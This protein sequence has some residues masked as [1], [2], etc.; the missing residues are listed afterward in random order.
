MT[1]A[2]LIFVILL[3]AISTPLSIQS[4]KT[5]AS[6]QVSGIVADITGARIVRAQVA[7]EGGGIRYDA[8]TG[9]EGEYNISLKPG[10]YQIEV[11][12]FGFCTARRAPFR[13]EPQATANFDFMLL[14]C[15]I[16]NRIITENGKYKGESCGPE[17]P[18]KKDLFPIR[19]ASKPSLDLMVQYGK[20]MEDSNQ[21]KYEGYKTSITYSFDGVTETKEKNLGVTVTYNLL[22][23]QADRVSLDK[24]NLILT[25]EGNVTVQDDKQRT[26]ANV[27]TVSFKKGVAEILTK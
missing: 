1:R 16:V 8:T 19:S 25:A 24:K 20:R 11:A 2:T 13:L 26:E 17:P 14:V 23:I 6:G 22:T 10:T 4:S 18:F 12:R 7:I 27:T 15:P 21:I 9:E 3:S 5:E